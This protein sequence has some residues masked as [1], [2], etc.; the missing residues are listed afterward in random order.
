MRVVSMPSWDLFEL[1]DA[2]YQESVLPKAVTRRVAVEAGIRMG[3]DRYVGPGGVFIGRETF[4]ASAPCQKLAEEFGFT[5][6]NVLAKAK[7]L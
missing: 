6:A 2:A 1:Q 3:W 5:V 4:G 7:S